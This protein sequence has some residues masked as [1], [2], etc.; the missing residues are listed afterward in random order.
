[1]PGGEPRATV[2]MHVGFNELVYSSACT[3]IHVHITKIL[4]KLGEKFN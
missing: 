3:Y 2:R 4:T 1:M